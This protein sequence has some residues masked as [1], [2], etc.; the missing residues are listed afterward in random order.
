MSRCAELLIHGLSEMCDCV[1]LFGGLA[2]QLCNNSH[3]VAP[4]VEVLRYEPDGRGFESRRC[5]WHFS[6]T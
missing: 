5:N 6:L 3:A 1:S 2:L 4:L